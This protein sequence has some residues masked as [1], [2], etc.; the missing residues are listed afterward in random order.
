MAY[1]I[2]TT[3]PGSMLPIQGQPYSQYQIVTR[4]PTGALPVVSA[5]VKPLNSPSLSPEG[6]SPFVVDPGCIRDNVVV[7]PL[8]QVIGPP[9]N[10][11]VIVGKGFE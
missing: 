9:L 5:A 8:A 6:H 10:N 3:V 1:P 7:S 2:L 11:V 4:P